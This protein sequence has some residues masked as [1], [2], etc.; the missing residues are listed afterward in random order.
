VWLDA[1][2]CK[3]Q[4]TKPMKFNG[5]NVISR[6]LLGLPLHLIIIVAKKNIIR[7][8]K[9]GIVINDGSLFLVFFPSCPPPLLHSSSSSYSDGC[10]KKIIK[11]KK[12]N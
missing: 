3:A 10:S 5:G 4:I 8:K 12:K 1:K 9:E 2:P 7:E 11:L 6:L